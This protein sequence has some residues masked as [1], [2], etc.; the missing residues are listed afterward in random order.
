[1]L[2]LESYIRTVIGFI[3]S[4]SESFE[5]LMEME[6]GCT[7]MFSRRLLINVGATASLSIQVAFVEAEWYF[8]AILESGNTS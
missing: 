7:R 8:N 2:H 6:K 5:P 4:K 1:M 3:F